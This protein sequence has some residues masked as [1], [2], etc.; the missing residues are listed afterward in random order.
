MP[1]KQQ[2]RKVTKKAQKEEQAINE[3]YKSMVVT[4]SFLPKPPQVIKTPNV[5][6]CYGNADALFLLQRR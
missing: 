1:K 5:V 6:N 3:T 2:K 4:K